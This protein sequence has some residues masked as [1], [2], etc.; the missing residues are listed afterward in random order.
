MLYLSIFV[1]LIANSALA[2]R[3]AHTTRTRVIAFSVYTLIFGILMLV[4]NLVVV[5]ADRLLAFDL[6]N[7]T[8]MNVA[9]G[10]VMFW[11]V[12]VLGVF[13]RIRRLGR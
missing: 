4:M 3:I 1:A 8:H 12:A 13:W 2:W 10:L 11:L 5:G 6:T 7:A 9:T